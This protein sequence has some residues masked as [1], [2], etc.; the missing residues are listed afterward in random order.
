[1]HRYDYFRFASGR[2]AF[3]VSA[4]SC[5][6]KHGRT[7]TLV[8]KAYAQVI[9]TVD[10]VLHRMRYKHFGFRTPSWIFK[11]MFD[12][13]V[14]GKHFPWLHRLRNSYWPIVQTLKPLSLRWLLTVNTHFCKIRTFKDHFPKCTLVPFHNYGWP[15]Y[16]C[17]VSRFG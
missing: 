17:P 4:L 6:R 9:C 12:V 16:Q 1:M 15:G 7:L 10:H 8:F 11:V 5:A 3:P 2:L 14:S 13:A